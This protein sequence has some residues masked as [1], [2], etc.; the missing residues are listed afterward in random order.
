MG[1]SFSQPSHPSVDRN[2][3]EIR[4]KSAV[5]SLPPRGRCRAPARRRGDERPLTILRNLPASHVIL[6]ERQRAEGSF[7]LLRGGSIQ[8]SA[9]V[10]GRCSF[11]VAGQETN[12]RSRVGRAHTQFVQ[13]ADEMGRQNA[14]YRFPVPNRET[15]QVFPMQLVTSQLSALPTAKDALL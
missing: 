6:S 10:D 1:F 13:S 4:H 8:P 14:R 12:Q 3:K 11:L 9:Y 5:P 7:L 2:Q 15:G